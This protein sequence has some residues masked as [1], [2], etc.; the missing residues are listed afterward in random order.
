M[1]LPCLILYC[2]TMYQ[3]ESLYR[4]RAVLLVVVILLPDTFVCYMVIYNI[5]YT[6]TSYLIRFLIRSDELLNKNYGR[7]AIGAESPISIPRIC[8]Y[9]SRATPSLS[10]DQQIHSSSNN[11]RNSSGV[12]HHKL[13][14]YK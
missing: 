4:S 8:L 6:C 3:S 12:D 5:C 7:F 2:I 11:S 14:L 13:L 10:V 1:T 9:S